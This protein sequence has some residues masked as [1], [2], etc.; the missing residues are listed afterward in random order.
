MVAEI[1]QR[2]DTIDRL[3]QALNHDV[4]HGAGE[5]LPLFL[6]YAERLRLDTETAVGVAQVIE[7]RL[8]EL[9]DRL[10]RLS[11]G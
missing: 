1:N 8:L 5:S 2:V 11:R 6:G 3:I 9:E 4:R 10:D 7:R